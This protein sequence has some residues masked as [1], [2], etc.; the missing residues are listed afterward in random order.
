LTNKRKKVEAQLSDSSVVL[1]QEERG[2][3]ELEL[4]HLSKTDSKKMEAPLRVDTD[5]MVH[6]VVFGPPGCG[7]SLMLEHL[8]EKQ[9]RRILNMDEIVD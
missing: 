6:I 4:V 2:R 7:K 5:K 8:Q 9:Q 1:S 3:L